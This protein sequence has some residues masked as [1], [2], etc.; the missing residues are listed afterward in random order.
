MS[1][2]VYRASRR[3]WSAFDPLDEAPSI[4]RDGWRFNDSSTAILYTAA[5]EALAILEL[6]ARPGWDTIGELAIAVIEVPADSVT[7]LED[8]GIVLPSNWNQR[9]SAPNA[10]SIGREFLHAVDREAA[11][12]RTICGVRVPT[13]ISHTDFNVLLDPRQKRQYRVTRRLRMPF[14]WT[15]R[16][17]TD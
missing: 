2:A 15:G 13:V 12:G 1:L 10:R 11:N 14:G 4:A 7:T 8:L 6:A 5:T 17:P 3:P 16:P 9:P